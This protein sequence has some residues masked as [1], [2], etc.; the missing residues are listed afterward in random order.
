M[1]FGNLSVQQRQGER[2]TSA[3]EGKMLLKHIFWSAAIV[4][5][6]IPTSFTD[7]RYY[8]SCYV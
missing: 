4:F 6:V 8:T 1:F 7:S 2:E 5:L 3:F